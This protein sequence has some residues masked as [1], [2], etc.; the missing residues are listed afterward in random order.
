MFYIRV[1]NIEGHLVMERETGV[2]TNAGFKECKEL[3]GGG[4]GGERTQWPKKKKKGFM[5][6][7]GFLAMEMGEE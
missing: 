5:R 7:G 3:G 6:M 1:E 2:G 4:G